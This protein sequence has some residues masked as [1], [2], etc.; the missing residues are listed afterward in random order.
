LSINL[1]GLG[2]SMV[3]EQVPWPGVGAQITPRKHSLGKR[4]IIDSKVP[5]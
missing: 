1:P 2:A 4:K 5:W 3:E